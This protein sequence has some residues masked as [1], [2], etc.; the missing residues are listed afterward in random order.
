MN[1][2]NS[3]GYLVPSTKSALRN[4]DRASLA[5]RGLA[6]LRSRGT[7]ESMFRRAM[8]FRHDSPNGRKHRHECIKLLQY[9]LA[10][11]PGHLTAQT[12]LGIEYSERGIEMNEARGIVLLQD[13][14]NAGTHM[15]SLVWHIP[16]CTEKEFLKTYSRQ[17]NGFANPQKADS[18]LRSTN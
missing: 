17:L 8:M 9:T 3:P 4:A 1:E 10:L 16:F 2:S 15:R 18:E 13:A 12:L 14:A 7:A 6:D 5:A 11:D